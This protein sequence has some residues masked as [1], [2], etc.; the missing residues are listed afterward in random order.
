MKNSK[1]KKT[2]IVLI[3]LIILAGIT[4]GYFIKEYQIY[5][6]LPK[7]STNKLNKIDLNKYNK[8][9]IVAHPDDELIW[10]GGHLIEDNYLVVC[11]TGGKD[12]T[13]SR[14]FKNVMKDT[15]D[16][17]LI[18][19]YPDKIAGKRSN[20]RLWKKDIQRDIETIIKYKEWDVVV[21]HNEKG[22]YG[23]QHHIM[24]HKIVD[25]ACEATKTS[26]KI[27]NFG[28]Y[29]KKSNLSEDG[30]EQINANILQKKEELAKNYG[31][32]SKTIKKLH[33][34]FP[35]ENWTQVY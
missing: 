16:V 4:L 35:Y 25:N 8:L 31:S 21:S 18:L 14:E 6:F 19:S 26:S 9:M 5:M 1:K 17:G 30:I 2:R 34:M 15:N 29:Y 11:V 28:K 27:M 33:H 13:R 3:S 20:W 24:T 32:Q 12:K 22:E 10:G 23:H 7:V